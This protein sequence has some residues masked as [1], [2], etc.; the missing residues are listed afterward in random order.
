MTAPA[1]IRR[2]EINNRTRHGR[3]GS[4]D[5]STRGLKHEFASVDCLRFDDDFAANG[6]RKRS[7]AFIDTDDQR[8][9]AP[10]QRTGTNRE[11]IRC[12]IETVAIALRHCPTGAGTVKRNIDRAV[13]VGI[14]P[15]GPRVIGRENASD[16]SDDNNPAFAIVAQRIDVPPPIAARRDGRIECKSAIRHCAAR[17][18]EIA[19]IGTPGPG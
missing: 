12:A 16:E 15:A 5:V 10:L 1:Q 19:A 17:R 4:P 11:A 8:A 6:A 14:A 7:R 13:A 3:D 18:P 2:F 9:I